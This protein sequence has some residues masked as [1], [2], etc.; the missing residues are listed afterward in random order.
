MEVWAKG[1]FMK[2]FITFIFMFILLFSIQTFAGM[3]ANVV[4]L[5]GGNTTNT[6][7]TT[8][9]IKSTTINMAPN[10][11]EQPASINPPENYPPPTNY[12]VI[13]GQPNGQAPM[14]S[15]TNPGS[16]LND[17][18]ITTNVQA[19]ILGD[20]TLMG[21]N[22]KVKTFNGVVTLEGTANSQE[23]VEAAEKI[24]KSVAGNKGV[25]SQITVQ[26]APLAAPAAH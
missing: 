1:V 16:A 24:A 4:P 8:T 3:T 26:A 11:N 14:S 10:L 20:V 19:R 9:N 15:P 18:D 23:Q 5:P 17:A 22:I 6:S 2:I 13:Q 7:N 12:P 25:Q 21:A